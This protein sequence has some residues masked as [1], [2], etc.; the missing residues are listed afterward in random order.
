M[1]KLLHADALEL[2]GILQGFLKEAPK[3]P[4]PLSDDATTLVWMSLLTVWLLPK[5]ELLFRD[6]CVAAF[7]DMKA[8][9]DELRSE[10]RRAERRPDRYFETDWQK[11]GLLGLYSRNDRVLFY[12]KCL[13]EFRYLKLLPEGK[14]HPCG[15]S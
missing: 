8:E 1:R 7:Q 15:V 6:F 3:H 2:R 10:I 4:R 12:E 13:A 9:V 11:P 14:N 5:T